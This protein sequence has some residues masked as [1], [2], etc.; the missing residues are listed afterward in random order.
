MSGRRQSLEPKPP[1]GDWA[2]YANCIGLPADWFFPS[3]GSPQSDVDQAKAVCAGCSVA[4]ACLAYAET[5]PIIMTGVWGGLSA[6]ERQ[7]LRRRRR[8]EA[9]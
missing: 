2:D 5:P 6:R 4:A 9:M 8:L 3:K 1:P 7:R